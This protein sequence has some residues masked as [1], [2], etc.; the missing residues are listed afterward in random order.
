MF[1]KSWVHFIHKKTPLNHSAVLIWNLDL[2]ST[3]SILHLSPAQIFLATSELNKIS[4]TLLSFYNMPQ[5][6]HLERVHWTA[7]LSQELAL[8]FK[9]SID[10]FDP[11]D[12]FIK[13]PVYHNYP[14]LVAMGS[15]LESLI[16]F[17]IKGRIVQSTKTS[18]KLPFLSTGNVANHRIR[19]RPWLALF[20]CTPA[21]INSTDHGHH[22]YIQNKVKVTNDLLPVTCGQ[23]HQLRSIPIT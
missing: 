10:Q 4:G 6:S 7:T 16:K 2:A 9:K 8:L 19:V 17:P 22:T 21:G 20:F 5:L 13:L 23:E 11:L 3:C 18:L 1:L 12:Q 15:N 14:H